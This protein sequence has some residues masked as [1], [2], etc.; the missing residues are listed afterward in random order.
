MDSEDYKIC[1]IGDSNVVNPHIVNHALCQRPQRIGQ[2]N[3]PHHSSAT[4]ISQTVNFSFT[5]FEFIVN[6]V[7]VFQCYRQSLIRSK[8]AQKHPKKI[9]WINSNRRKKR[10]LNDDNFEAERKSKDEN[11]NEENVNAWVH[12]VHWKERKRDR[13]R[14]SC[15]RHIFASTKSE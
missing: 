15:R 4:H 5:V 8:S 10:A 12:G 2:K 11:S 6:K 7:K 13:S 3:L 9:C 1:R 14:S